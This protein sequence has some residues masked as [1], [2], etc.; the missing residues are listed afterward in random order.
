MLDE[1]RIGMTLCVNT[2]SAILPCLLIFH[3]PGCITYPSLR[4]SSS[5]SKYVGQLGQEHQRLCAPCIR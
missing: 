4:S 1:E 3:P 5:S 2:Y